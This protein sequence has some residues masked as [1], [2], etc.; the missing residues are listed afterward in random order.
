[1]TGKRVIRYSNKI[2]YEGQIITDD[3]EFFSVFSFPFIEGDKETALYSPNS[4]VISERF[5]KKYFGRENPIGKILTMDNRLDFTVTGVIENVPSNSHLKFDMAVPFDVVEKLGWITEAWDFSMALTYLHLQKRT[6]YQDL[7][8][9]IAG[10]VKNYDK[11]T[12]IELFLKPLTRIHLY[13]SYDNPESKGRIQ[14]V[15]VFALVGVIILLIACINFMNLATARSEYRSK[16]IGMRKVIGAGKAH[17]VRQFLVEAVFLALLS[18][19]LVPLLIKLVLP[20]FNEITGETFTLSSFA[21]LKMI[22]LIV[23]VTLLAGILSG[24]YPALFLSSFQPVRVMY[25]HIKSDSKG[26]FIRKTLVLAQMS[27]SLILLVVSAIIYSQIDYLKN[28]D[29]GSASHGCRKSGRHNQ[30][31]YRHCRIHCLPRAFCLVLLCGRKTDK[32]DRHT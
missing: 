6:D 1:M 31:L 24:S 23:G 4:V 32:G 26:S 27:I 2:F 13:T 21:N 18:L 22:L 20:A 10:F 12:N 29:L 11:E 17:I 19:F 8:Q 3:P 15:Y 14:Y 28:K 9:K 16:E 25:G 5:A 30:V 7:E